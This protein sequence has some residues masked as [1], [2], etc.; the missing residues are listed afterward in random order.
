M[1]QNWLRITHQDDKIQ[2]SWQREQSAPRSAPPV[3]FEHPF[4]EQTLT[5]LRW[6][7]EEYLDFPYGIFPEQAEKIEQKFQEW[8]Q[9]LF[10]LVFPRTTKAWD[11]FQ[12]ATREGLDKCEI[13]I[14]SDD[15]KVLN[16]PWELLY[17]PDYQFL[18]PS[19]RGMYRSLNGYAV[20]SLQL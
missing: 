2:L 8:G 19:L 4:N 18:A 12:E 17:T 5:E 3:T 9:Q 1:A 10:E 13:N 11:F 14:S 16:L 7:L 20:R 6:Y 15:P